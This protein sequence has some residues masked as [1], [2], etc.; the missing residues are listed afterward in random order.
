MTNAALSAGQ[1]PGNVGAVTMTI[2]SPC[3]VTFTSHGFLGGERVMIRTTGAL[4]T[5]LTAGT[6]YFIKY[7]DAT[8]FNLAA[9]LGGS[10]INTSGSQSGT[11]TLNSESILFTTATTPQGYN[12][13]FRFKDNGG[14]T[15]SVVN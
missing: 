11:H 15:H 5:G 7:I 13:N 4:P 9:T 6:V 1:G 2:A 14:T 8:T 10:N 3:V 12:L